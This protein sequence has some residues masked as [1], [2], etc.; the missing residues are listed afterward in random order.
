MTA[1][2]VLSSLNYCKC[3][4]P[5]AVNAKINVTKANYRLPRSLSPETYK[6]QIFTH[7]N[8][9]EIFK[10][11]GD[12]QITVSFLFFFFFNRTICIFFSKFLEYIVDQCD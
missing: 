3:D 1:V 4:E 10:F 12:V 6:L 9:A 8:D 5:I 11:Y 2:I 7:L